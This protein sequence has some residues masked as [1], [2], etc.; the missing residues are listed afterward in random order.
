MSRGT[1]VPL[2]PSNNDVPR[3]VGS[4]ERVPHL[5]IF[6]FEP[7]PFTPTQWADHQPPAPIHK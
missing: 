7:A 3:L 6:F 4:A 1:T 2:L 5:R